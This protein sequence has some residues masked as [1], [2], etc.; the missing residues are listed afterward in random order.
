MKAVNLGDVIDRKSKT[1]S[2]GMKRRLSVAIASISNPKL[3][4]ADEPTTG[5]DPVSKRAVWNLILELRKKSVI[6]LTTHILEE[7]GTPQSI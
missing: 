7:A 3:I 4:F 2:G 6:L 1:F 5:L